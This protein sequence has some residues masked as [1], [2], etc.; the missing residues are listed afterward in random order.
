MVFV[1]GAPFRP[2]NIYAISTSRYVDRGLSL[3]VGR[4]PMAKQ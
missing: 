2:S 3:N 4:D 1:M